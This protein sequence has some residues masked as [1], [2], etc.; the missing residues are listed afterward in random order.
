MNVEQVVQRFPGA[1]KN[2]TG[3][4][5]RC[6]VPKHNDQ[7]AQLSVGEGPDG[8]VILKCHGGCSIGEV[9]A[10]A[11]GLSLPDLFPAVSPSGAVH[12]K[13]APM[14][15]EKT[16]D[17]RD[18]AGALMYQNVRRIHNGTRSFKM[19][20]PDGEGGWVWSMKGVKLLPY[21][22]PDIAACVASGHT[23]LLVVIGENDADRLWDEGIAATT[24]IGGRGK[25]SP[26]LAKQLRDV[27]VQ[28]VV[29]IPDNHQ[30][31]FQHAEQV[32]S[33][34]KLAGLSVSILML[35]GLPPRGG[36]SA[37]FDQGHTVQELVTL[38]E[39]Q[40]YVLAPGA[41]TPPAPSPVAAMPQQL[42]TP[43]Q[44]V[45]AD[46]T[47]Y[48]KTDLG[49]AEAFR[50]RCHERVRYDHQREEWL[51]WNG[52]YWKPDANEQVYNLA[53]E[54]VRAWQSEAL[55]FGDFGLKE[56]VTKFTLQMEKGGLT[57]A[58]VKVARR[59]P[60]ISIA[61][62][63]WDTNPMVLGCP[64]G[65]VDLT[66]GQLREGRRDDLVTKQVGV[67]YDPFA[68]CP[69][70]EQFM[71]EVFEDDVPLMHFVHKALGYSMT[72]DMREQVFFLLLGTGSNGKSIFLDTLERI[73]GTY[74]MRAS[75]QIFVGDD[76]K[77][78]YHMADLAGSR[79]V[80]AAETKPNV[81]WKEHNI[82]NY[83][84]GETQR[85]EHKFGHP[86]TFKPTGKIWLGM[87][88]QPKVGDDSYG[89]WRRVRLI[90]FNRTFT[91]ATADPLLS[92]T[93]KAE[94]AGILR[95]VV[96]G[97]LLWQQEG[98]HAPTSVMAAT[99]A[100]QQSEDPLTEFLMERTVHDQSVKHVRTKFTV[101]FAAY[102]AW[103]DK[104]G[105]HKNDR[106]TRRVFGSNLKKWFQAD[107]AQGRREYVGV[108][109]K[110][111]ERE[112]LW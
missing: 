19:R 64:N 111:E 39:Q 37:W 63:N 105:I 100:Y 27:G 40:P 104:E 79:F 38:L 78:K 25:W 96:Q 4:W 112:K 91:G 13:P 98:L 24:N 12:K 45:G 46:G 11:N 102:Q 77:E 87:N 73:W 31:G 99:D 42:L 90:P 94:A 14:P 97:A 20:R 22:L 34:C 8:R 36:V 60:P 71:R 51:V 21:R 18:R 80:F 58:F 103:A 2:G 62:G 16:F 52:H 47:I 61:G 72:G 92:E 15:A 30:P 84:G 109:L 86:F 106:L 68:V 107:E 3:W 5:A 41:S 69:R 67:A 93:L 54:H 75:M 44:V 49:A 57:D 35:Q 59:L 56:R 28:R 76:D 65:I 85:G 32:A 101:L 50:D 1:T 23:R 82:K 66:T 33:K 83:T 74:G 9:L 70:W 89:F 10:H 55:G 26:T 48:N 110:P 29:I 43:D 53:Y 81:R 95:W 7:A 108:Q 17:Y 6:P 88:H